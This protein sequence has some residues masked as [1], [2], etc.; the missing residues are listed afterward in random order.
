M[1]N[2]NSRIFLVVSFSFQQFKYVVALPFYLWPSAEKSARLPGVVLGP[3]GFLEVA[4][5]W[6]SE[7]L[8]L[9][10]LAQVPRL[11]NPTWLLIPFSLGRTSDAVASFLRRV[12]AHEVWILARPRL[13]P[14]CFLQ[15]CPSFI[16]LVMEN[17]SWQT[18]SFSQIIAQRVV[19]SMCPERKQTK[20][21]PTLPIGPLPHE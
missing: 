4:P 9:F 6:L 12:T 15:C 13:R 7:P 2:L 19:V 1:T 5:R 3:T 20:D 11:G 16:S 18:R 10:L 14:T 17:P 8:L 21:F